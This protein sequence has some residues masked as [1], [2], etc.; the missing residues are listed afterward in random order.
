MK[1]TDY[2]PIAA[3]YDRHQARH[4]NPPDAHLGARIESTDRPVRALDVACGTGNYVAAQ[5]RA[6]G[7]TRVAWHGVDASPEMLDV[8]R[9]KLP[10]V[11]LREGRAEALPFDDESFDYVSCN[12][13]F[14]HFEDKHAALDEMRRVLR[15]G[16]GLRIA[17]LGVE[18][19]PGWW[20]FRFFPEARVEDE[21]R[22]WSTELVLHE[23]WRRGF[24]AETEGRLTQRR[25]PAKEL[26]EIARPRDLSSL[27]IVSDEQFAAGLAQLE[28]LAA[29]DETVLD[30]QC[31]VVCSATR[32][33]D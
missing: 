1:R 30:T 8:A 31:V 18:H 23:L 11:E 15:P 14:H 29:R 17:N 9:G 20:L 25:K 13:A 16:G 21:K 10:D 7:P 3:I 12:F 2:G 19:M 22:F 6:F 33:G 5:R 28:A 4:D 24:D 27:V 26:A 32:A